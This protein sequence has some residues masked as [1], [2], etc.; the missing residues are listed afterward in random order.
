MLVEDTVSMW[1]DPLASPGDRFPLG[2]P[3]G[4]LE[5][6]SDGP[7]GPGTRPY[8]LRRVVAGARLDAPARWRFSYCPVQQVGLVH[9]SDG[10][11]VPLVKHTKPGPT[12][13]TTSG[14]PDG[15]P[16]KPPPE[17]MGPSDY[18]QT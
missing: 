12:P 15:D 11:V 1:S 5:D 8:S 9:E 2:P 16:R 3:R 18:Q 4:V 10:S 7:S 6:W 13:G 17:E 14:V